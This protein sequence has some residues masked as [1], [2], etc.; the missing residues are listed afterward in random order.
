MQLL[1]ETYENIAQAEEYQR[2]GLLPIAHSTQKAHIEITLDADGTF[3]DADFVADKIGKESN[4]SETLIPV[5]EASASRSSGIAPHPLADKLKY[6]ASDYEEYTGEN[7]ENYISDYLIQLEQWKDSPYTTPKVNA[8]YT[9]LSEASLIQDLIQAGIF[10][11]SESGRLT[12]K[13]ENIGDLKLS[14]GNQADAFLRFRVLDGSNTPNTWE[15]SHLQERYAAYYLLTMQHQALCYVSGKVTSVSENH[16][17]KI[18]HSGD[19]AKLISANDTSGYTYRGRFQT[20]SDAVQISYEISQKAHNALKFLIKKQGQRIG[21][22]VFLLWGTKLESLPL[23]NSDSCSLFEDEEDDLSLY[24]ETQEEAAKKFNHAMLGYRSQIQPDTKFAILGLDAATTGRMS[25]IYHRE[26]CGEECKDLLDRI[27]AWHQTSAWLHRYLFREKTPMPF[28]GA[29]SPYDIALCAYGTEQNGFLK[30]KDKIIASATERI[31]PCISD[32]AKIPRDIVTA[33]VR[34]CYTPEKYQ[35]EWNWHKV[36]TVT[37]SMYKKY[38]YD[39]ESEVVE[40][41]TNNR[42]SLSFQCGRL[43]AVAHEAEQYAQSIKGSKRTTNAMRYFNSFSHNPC[44]TWKVIRNQLNPYL[45]TLGQKAMLYQDLLAEISASIEET[46]FQAARNLD[47]EMA[48]GFDSQRKEIKEHIKAV[49]EQ[50]KEE[51]K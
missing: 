31:L 41:A 4:L 27:E 35:N 34:K 46:A 51:E 16:P 44:R 8:I 13:W 11:V 26:Y 22:K 30:G 2:Q 18:R 42:N 10:S 15:D 36:L 47:G 33:L 43:L 48:L 50:K 49:A 3:V 9:Y 29:P 38:L 20:G 32:G 5:T 19:R 7:N 21:E 45:I 23:L 39:Y 25:I 24:G 6:L 40:M 17:S 37:C 12:E 28:Y 1:Y 14:A